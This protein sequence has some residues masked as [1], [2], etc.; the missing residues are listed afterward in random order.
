MNI[1][2]VRMFKLSLSVLIQKYIGFTQRDIKWS[3]VDGLNKL[4]H[5]VD[6]IEI[7]YR[8]D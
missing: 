2:Q 3:F 1:S 4:M 6:L 5:Y 8:I 7:E